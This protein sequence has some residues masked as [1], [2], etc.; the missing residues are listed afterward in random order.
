MI[1]VRIMMISRHK[2][3]RLNLAFFL[4]LKQLGVVTRLLFRVC[5]K[6]GKL[7]TTGDTNH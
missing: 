7:R 2:P 5:T 3:S 1:T 4:P 6:R